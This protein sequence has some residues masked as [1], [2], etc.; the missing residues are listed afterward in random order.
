M[1]A[2][3]ELAQNMLWGFFA[4]VLLLFFGAV[5]TIGYQV[6]TNPTSTQIA[7]NNA[8]LQM[9]A[10]Q[11]QS[12]IDQRQ[13]AQ[14]AE[15]EAR[16]KNQWAFFEEQW[17]NPAW[18]LFTTSIPAAG[19]LVMWALAIGATTGI[20]LLIYAA[21]ARRDPLVWADS[22]GSLPVD[23]REVRR[24]TPT[25]V[26]LL[27]NRQKTEE[28]KARAAIEA[29]TRQ[30][31]HSLTYSPHITIKNDKPALPAPSEEAPAAAAP[32]DVPSFGDLLNQG[33][34][35]PDAPLLLGFNVETG[36]PIQGGFNSI[37]SLL[38]GGLT[39][40][41][42]TTSQ[43]HLAAMLAL[44]GCK[45]V[46][47]DPHGES[48]EE[49]LAGTLAPLSGAYMC[50]VAIEDSE[51]LAAVRL[52]A[53]IGERRIKGKDES[54]ELVMLWVDEITSLLQKE[55]I[56]AELGKLIEEIAR[57][58]RKVGVFCSA[59]GQNWSAARSGGNSALRESF[60][61]ILCHRL[62]RTSARMLVPAGEA[63]L[64][65]RLPAG[66]ALLW[67]ATG[68]A[69][70]VAMPNCTQRDIEGVARLIG[71]HMSGISQAYSR[72]TPQLTEDPRAW[73]DMPEIC[74]NMPEMPETPIS[75][76]AL[77][78]ARLFLEQH[79]DP[80]AIVLTMRGI[81]SNQGTKYQ[82]ALAEI[83]ELI[84][85]GTPVIISERAA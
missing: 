66:R 46:V 22:A 54:R 7:Q 11:Q 26:G 2:V 43:R 38:I 68:E 75:A 74:R 45:F 25:S 42:K 30:V 69:T 70:V 71:G 83:C 13:A 28:T 12:E 51:I 20:A 14:D 17:I 84:R 52:V 4:I 64:V 62:R 73:V 48:G 57:Q 50:D 56:G 81:R 37:Y 77:T 49:S 5:A 29:T 80:A 1:E 10:D 8:R 63:A 53:D 23:R 72:H 41:G 59:S 76:E 47:A 3:K 16:Q 21:W 44:K 60:A 34:I 19:M 61:S 67:R 6:A 24:L 36:E 40:S 78:A 18:A 33:L 55:Q 85:V 27:E 65:E 9:Q 32:V 58:Y 15:I 82:A 31:P 79:M 39:G 35:G